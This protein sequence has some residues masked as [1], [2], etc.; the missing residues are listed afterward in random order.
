M[1]SPDVEQES[2]VEY[3]E[4]TTIMEY[5]ETSTAEYHETSIEEYTFSATASRTYSPPMRVPKRPNGPNSH[6]TRSSPSRVVPTAPSD[7]AMVLARSSDTASRGALDTLSFDHEFKIIQSPPYDRSRLPWH[8]NRHVIFLLG[9][10]MLAKYIPTFLYFWLC[11]Y[12]HAPPHQN[13]DRADLRHLL[14]F[15]R[16][17][18][19]LYTIVTRWW[20]GN[21]SGRILF[22]TKVVNAWNE[23]QQIFSNLMQSLLL[24]QSRAFAMTGRKE[25]DA[26]NWVRMGDTHE[27]EGKLFFRQLNEKDLGFNQ[28]LSDFDRWNNACW[29]WLEA[30]GSES[31]LF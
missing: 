19:L 14:D 1:A 5:H 29:I 20:S 27:S 23:G 24:A 18:K 17:M 22:E 21:R 28:V 15:H 16:V 6:D 3:H 26:A 13:F 2:I 30:P 10:D 8:Q 4:T 31:L 11:R 12:Q 25:T 7:A 9:R